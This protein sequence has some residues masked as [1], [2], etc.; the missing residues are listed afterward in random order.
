[1]RNAQ[2]GANQSKLPY[3]LQGSEMGEVIFAHDWSGSGL[4]PLSTWPN[5]LKF[6]VNMVLLMPSPAILLWGRDLLQIYNDSC[7]NLMRAKH[8]IC[9]SQP[10]RECWPEIWDCAS[11]ICD[12]VMRRWE[13]FDFEDVHLRVNRNG[14]LEEVFVTLTYS[15]VPGNY[16]AE[17]PD[18]KTIERGEA[19]GVRS[20]SRPGRWS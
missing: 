6:A 1:M 16:F 4:G 15:P 2:V 9:L 7:R 19:G 14:A 10:I 8:S 17:I 13:S 12:S 11:T 20:P 5:Y 3:W 18:G